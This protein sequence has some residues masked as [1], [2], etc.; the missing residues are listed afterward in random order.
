MASPDESVAREIEV[1]REIVEEVYGDVDVDSDE[2]SDGNALRFKLKLLMMKLS[3]LS[4][5][6]QANVT[7]RTE[8]STLIKSKTTE[9]ESI[10]VLQRLRQLIGWRTQ[11][12]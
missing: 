10:L 9:T 11:N 3:E 12:E 4:V 6:V 2:H 8:I 7:L 5:T 1:V